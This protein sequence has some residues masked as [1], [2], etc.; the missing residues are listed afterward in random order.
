MVL[1]SYLPGQ[2]RRDCLRREFYDKAGAFTASGDLFLNFTTLGPPY[3][4]CDQYS[5]RGKDL[6]R[7]Q[8]VCYD[9]RK[10]R[11]LIRSLKALTVELT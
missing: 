11:A 4:Y 3:I 7:I 6:G 2:I 8:R 9:F 1:N 5:A 10:W